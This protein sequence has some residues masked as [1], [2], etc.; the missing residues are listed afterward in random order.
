[1][2]QE[3]RSP[4]DHVN[5]LPPPESRAE[6]TIEKLYIYDVDFMEVYFK[7]RGT[8]VCYRPIV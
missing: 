3:S 4:L 1:M 6:E 2:S 7:P 8:K 5:Y